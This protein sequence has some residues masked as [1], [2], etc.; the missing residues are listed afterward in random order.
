ML[1]LMEL[2]E[3]PDI[4][5]SEMRE[6]LAD[7]LQMPCLVIVKSISLILVVFSLKNHPYTVTFCIGGQL[8]SMTYT[9]T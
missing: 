2:E 6:T 9:S 3:F 1:Q 8:L 4:W 5:Y 7:L